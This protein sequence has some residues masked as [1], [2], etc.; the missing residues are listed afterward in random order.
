MDSKLFERLLHVLLKCPVIRLDP[1]HTEEPLS[2]FEEKNCFHKN[3][4]P[5]FTKAVLQNILIDIQPKN[6]YEIA[7][8]IKIFI[9]L[10]SFDNAFYLIGP[11]V[12][13]EYDQNEVEKFLVEYHFPA[14]YAQPLKLYYN[15]LPLIYQSQLS[16]I[17]NSCITA[18][19]PGTAEFLYQ[20]LENRNFIK[21]KQNPSKELTYNNQKFSDIYKRYDGENAFQHL[22]QMGDVENVLTMQHAM[23]DM[24]QSSGM[25]QA[26]SSYINPSVSFAILRTLARKAAERSG[27][28]VITIDEIT[29]KYAQLSDAAS[30]L[31]K[32]VECSKNMILELTSAVRNHQLNYAHYPKPVVQTMEYIISHLSEDLRLSDLADNVTLSVTGLCKLFKAET[33]MTLNEY[34]T[35]QRCK[36]AAD[37]LSQTDFQIQEIGS[38]VGYNDNNYFVKVFKKVYNCTP[39]QYRK[40]HKETA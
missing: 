22:I 1:E 11:Y 7:D 20:H 28:S 5:L 39:S 29:N 36:K 17:I 33:G 4:Q 24:A 23:L 10:F 26:N 40:K 19:A 8:D 35:T 2:A 3:M 30:T 9:S 6:I 15:S 25:L 34:L 38:H 21:P 27:L 12:K 16:Y 18:F 31:E 32:Q 37:L 13:K 14:S